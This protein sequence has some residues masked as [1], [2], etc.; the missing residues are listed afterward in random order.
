MEC[1]AGIG[2]ADIIKRNGCLSAVTENI[3]IMMVIIIVVRVVPP[4]H[5][6]QAAFR[7]MVV[8]FIIARRLKEAAGLV[9]PAVQSVKY[10]LLVTD[11]IKRAAVF[12]PGVL[13]RNGS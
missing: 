10:G 1:S 12:H 9:I 8:D 11:E 4:A 6:D 2:F 13:H 7:R 5:E 3:S